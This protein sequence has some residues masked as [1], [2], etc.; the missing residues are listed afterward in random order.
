MHTTVVPL[1][2]LTVKDV[3]PGAAMADTPRDL[4]RVDI[5]PD[6]WYPLA[7]SRELKRGKTHA[8]RFAG[9]PI[10]LVRTGTGKVFALEDRCAHRQVPLHAGVVEGE[11]IRCCYHGWT[12]DCAGKCID[13]PYLGRERLPN[14]VRAYPCR[15]E[16]GLIFV[17]PG[18]P[19]LAETV[20][21]PTLGSVADPA[22][23][24]RR[25]GREVQCHYS[26]MHENLMDMNHQ[27]LHRRQMGQMQARSLGR[28]K[29]EDWVEVEYTFSRMAGKQPMGEALVF[30]ERR[31]VGAK[32]ADANGGDTKGSA[33]S[34]KDVMTIRTAY[35]Y[36]TLRIET[37][38]GTRV[39]DLWIV[40]VPLDAEQRTNRTF[41]LLSIRKPKL[42]P[43]L[44]VAWPLLVWFTERIFK[45]DRWIVEREQAAHD[46]QGED[47]NHE[48]F[49]VILDLRALLR[50]CGAPAGFA[51]RPLTRRSTSADAGH[52]M[53]RVPRPDAAS[54]PVPADIGEM[55]ALRQKEAQ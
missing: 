26:F 24:T 25:F 8:V 28:R 16:Q 31:R 53:Q 40:Y 55:A 32:S 9:D 15:E 6:H 42:A 38:D 23:K 36:Q 49:P 1:E 41:G 17:F 29:S 18:D 22:Y 37:S 14:G 34:P 35:P 46:R 13:V 43:L 45:E 30:G 19:A 47:L 21:F 54:L 4:R 39:M 12:Y 50:E 27:F 52:A 51:T 44:D 33:G 3:P 48:V 7:W 5:H 10:V 11:T 2:S 20:P